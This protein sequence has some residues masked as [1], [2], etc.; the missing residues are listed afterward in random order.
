MLLCLV[1]GM[2]VPAFAQYVEKPDM[3]ILFA[4]SDNWVSRDSVENGLLYE[5]K[6]AA[7]DISVIVVPNEWAYSLEILGEHFL[8]DFCEEF[9]SDYQLGEAKIT[10]DGERVYSDAS[11]MIIEGRTFVPIRAVAEKNG[12]FRKLGWCKSV[13]NTSG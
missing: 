9:Y 8:Q 12:L 4:L 11:S 10:I 5:H 13:G 1:L 2:S 7:E 6:I 3:G